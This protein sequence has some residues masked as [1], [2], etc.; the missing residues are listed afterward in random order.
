MPPLFAPEAELVLG[1]VRSTLMISRFSKDRRLWRSRRR[2]NADGLVSRG[3]T[4]PSCE[5]VGSAGPAKP[6]RPPSNSE[7]DLSGSIR[8]ACGSVDKPLL[9]TP[10]RIEP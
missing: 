2:H 6:R 10:M 9:Q 1:A 8:K 3:S 4:K 7:F 5:T